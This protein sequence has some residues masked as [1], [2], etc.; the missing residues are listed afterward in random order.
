MSAI[1]IDYLQSWVGREIVRK[2]VLSVF[3][4]QALAAALDR[5][6]L[7]EAGDVLPPAWQWLYFKETPLARN[8][9]IDGHPRT[10]NFLPPVPLPRRM[11]AAG[12]FTSERPLLIGQPAQQ[13]SVI[14]AV[15]L[16][17]GSSGTLVFVTVKHQ[18]SQSGELCCLEKQHLVY[19]EMPSAPSPA[20]A[21]RPAPAGADFKVSFYADSVLLFRY[22]AL[23]YNAHRIHYDRNYAVNQEHYPGLVVHGPLLATLLAEQVSRHFPGVSVRHFIFRAIRPAFEGEQLRLC[24]RR[25][26]DQI[27]LWTVNQAGFVTMQATA[28]LGA[29][30]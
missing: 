17:Q 28:T 13:R 18:L 19:R 2:D 5:E 15:E 21:G 3:P 26:G 8:T 22:S 24:G 4:A 6:Q 29:L 14:S 20:P 27:E 25:D 16:K 30:S 1:D 23:T 12:E 11:W 9:N 7:P 10:G